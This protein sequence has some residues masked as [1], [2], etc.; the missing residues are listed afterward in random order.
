MVR[1]WQAGDHCMYL[2]LVI[3]LNIIVNTFLLALTGFI[4][5]QR[6]TSL[7]VLSGGILGASCL[8]FLYEPG[9]VPFVSV[10]R[11]LLPFL[12][13]WVAFR[14]RCWEHFLLLFFVFTLTTFL[15]GGI[16][17]SFSAVIAHSQQNIAESSLYA[18]PSVPFFIIAAS[19]LY[20]FLRFLVYPLLS[21]RL[22]FRLPSS[23]L[24]LE[25]VFQGKKKTMHA[26]L[27]TGN[28]LKEP[29]TGM[30]VAVAA[31][32]AVQDLL[33][34]GVCE[35]IR[36]SP[37]LDWMKMENVYKQL[38][39]PEIFTWVPYHS[40]GGSGFLL[41]F[42]PEQVSVWNGTQWTAVS[43]TLLVAIKEKPGVVS[44]EDF[45]ILLPL[46]IWLQVEAGEC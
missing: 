19:G 42:K 38:D 41:A 16:I 31:Y 30:P 4:A 35:L 7:R 22:R 24:A 34:R 45:E 32:S 6:T 23:T 21:R 12:M 28:M 9:I 18:V 10:F 39:Q 15:F 14:P 36:Q 27:D 11:F 44:G 25:L 26:Y 29:F 2:D 1:W 17:I 3:I 43:N 13:L 46:E 40:I 20:L 33:P 8:L 37:G 5:R